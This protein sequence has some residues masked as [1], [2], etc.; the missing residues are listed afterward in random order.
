MSSVSHRESPVADDPR[1]GMEARGSGS[2]YL[3][4]AAA[5]VEGRPVTIPTANPPAAPA[6]I[7]IKANARALSKIVA[8]PVL[9]FRSAI[10]FPFALPTL[11]VPFY[12]ANAP[13]VEANGGP[14]V[15][16]KT[17]KATRRSH[18]PMNSFV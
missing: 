17:N 13:L 1:G 16:A 3:P 4:G 18:C 5:D 6:R 11:Y 14:S 15:T 9:F 12:M 7:P 2:N 8:F 10:A